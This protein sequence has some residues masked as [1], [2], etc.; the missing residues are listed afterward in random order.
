MPPPPADPKTD[1]SRMQGSGVITNGVLQND[2]FVMQ[3]PFI[4]L[5]GAGTADLSG[6]VVDYNLNAKVNGSPR[7]DDGS[8][9]DELRGLNL[10]VSIKGPVEEPDIVI[11]LTAVITGLATQK[12]QDR[13][14]KKYGGQPEES[15]GEATEEPASDAPVSEREQRKELLRKGIRDLLN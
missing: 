9:L 13:L 1:I 4:A 8:N 7:F 2:D 14:L 5:T 10:P 11:D 12:L 6:A 15:S 3:V